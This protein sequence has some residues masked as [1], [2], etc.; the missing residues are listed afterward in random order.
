MAPSPG[1][2]LESFRRRLIGAVEGSARFSQGSYHGEPRLGAG[3]AEFAQLFL[4]L[5]G[6]G[7]HLPY[8]FF[9]FTPA[10]GR[11]FLSIALR[12]QNRLF[13]QNR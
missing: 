2:A 11:E 10:L 1:G 3:L 4:G 8:G 6:I 7:I 12:V 9:N 13:Q 5:G